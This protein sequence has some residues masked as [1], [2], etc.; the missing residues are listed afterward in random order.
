MLLTLS[1][2]V[3]ADF[4]KGMAEPLKV[5]KQS[6]KI[7]GGAD[8]DLLKAYAAGLVSYPVIPSL[9]DLVCIP[10]AGP[11]AVSTTVGVFADLFGGREESW[12][13]AY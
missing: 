6:G 13:K 3:S 8:G 4:T 11:A 2:C 7:T 5:L 1:A 10:S 12:S 9:P